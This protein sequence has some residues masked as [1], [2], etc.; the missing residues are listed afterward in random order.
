[1]T[2]TGIFRFASVANEFQR[3]AKKH[4]ER[5]NKHQNTEILDNIINAGW[6]NRMMPFELV[7]KHSHS[8]HK[9]SVNSFEEWATVRSF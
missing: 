9:L 1:M 6:F 4:E 3:F 8:Y 7:C 5:L 2:S